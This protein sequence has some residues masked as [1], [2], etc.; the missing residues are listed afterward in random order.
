[1][2]MP[3]AGNCLTL[4]EMECRFLIRVV[5]ETKS[6]NSSN[7]LYLGLLVVCRQWWLGHDGNALQLP[8]AIEDFAVFL[9]T[10][11]QEMGNSALDK[12]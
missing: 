4:R 8:L 2:R 12:L 1:M 6:N 11:Q 3:E 9:V 10:F 5:G 7:Y